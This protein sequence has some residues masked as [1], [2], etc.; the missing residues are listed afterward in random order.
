M[1]ELQEIEL[2]KSQSRVFNFLKEHGSITSLEAINTLHETRLGARIWELKK[3]GIP[4]QSK[5][6]NVLNAFKEKR[7]VKQYFFSE[8]E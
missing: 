7:H 8:G 1:E 6:I 4:I 5:T 2:N 3:K